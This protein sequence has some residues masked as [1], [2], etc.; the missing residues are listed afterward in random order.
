LRGAGQLD[1]A[2][3]YALVAAD[4][5]RD[6]VAF[7]RAAS[8][9]RLALELGSHE[10]SERR[11]IEVKLGHALA[12]SG[13]GHEA[14][15]AYFAAAEGAL[16]AEQLELRRRAADQLL[17]SGHIDEG[18]AAI[19][20]VLG[21]L[22]M[23]LASS[24][25][26][27]LQSVL[28]RRIWIRLRGLGFRIRD[29]SQMSDEEVVRVDACWTVATAIGVVDTICGADYQARHLILALDAGDPFR[30]A[31]ALALDSAYV[32]LGGSRTVARQR[33]LT[34][35]AQ[36]LADQVR[37]PEMH[38]YVTLARGIGA[39]FQG[40]WKAAHE[41]LDRAEPMLRECA[42]SVAWELDTAYLYHLLALFY[43]GDVTELSYRLPGFLKDARDRDDL[44]AS[45][46]L[47]TRVA[48]LMHLAAD[49]PDGAAEEVRQGMEPW[50]RTAF[51][52][53][54]S[55]EMYA[56]GE[57]ELYRAQGSNAW[58][59]VNENWHFLRRSLLLRIQAVLMPFKTLVLGSH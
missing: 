46:N 6:A 8:Y 4:R 7:D 17:R 16:A 1:I 26:R 23:E 11:D 42:T 41:L 36:R 18:L 59:L 20:Q 5:A 47:R 45:T 29:R 13:R 51:N 37:Q 56:C 19:R 57:I 52:A 33:A 31:R 58:R 54:H 38:A 10:P 9:Y 28:F 12:A 22:G 44:T 15:Q 25:V 27:A 39:F 40:Q 24:P 32:A 2:A 43:L 55:W 49:N 53:Q 35:L 50:A 34:E 48:Y 30:V 21:A 14:A 3:E